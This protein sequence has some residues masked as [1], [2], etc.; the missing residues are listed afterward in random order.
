MP[1]S[2]QR[3]EK[4]DFRYEIVEHFGVLSTNNKGWS[5]ELN[6]VEWNGR[7]AKLDLR[8]WEPGH[9]KM[10]KGVTMTVEEAF[11]LYDLLQKCIDE[12]RTDEETGAEEEA[13]E[14]TA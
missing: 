14:K 12:Y 7:P 13:A 11:E 9:S 6:L 2:F 8:E 4:D 3:K 10:S 5:K 1:G